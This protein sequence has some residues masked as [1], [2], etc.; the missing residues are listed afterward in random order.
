MATA[1]HFDILTMQA[2]SICIANFL[3]GVK[4][5][6]RPGNPVIIFLNKFKPLKI[7]EAWDHLLRIGR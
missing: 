2:E 3:P 1:I 5:I 6:N 7:M 4:Q